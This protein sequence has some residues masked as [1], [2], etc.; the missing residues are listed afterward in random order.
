MFARI[1]GI[2]HVNKLNITPS[3]WFIMVNTRR[4]SVKI[5]ENSEKI[6]ETTR[7]AC[8]IYIISMEK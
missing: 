8:Q 1:M 3:S 2:V 4:R 7:K 5:Q 6:Q